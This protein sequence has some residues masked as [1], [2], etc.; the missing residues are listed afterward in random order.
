MVKPKVR[1]I[2][3]GRV[4]VES[5]NVTVVVPTWRQ[6]M[7]LA[8]QAAGMLASLERIV[9]EYDAAEVERIYRHVY[10]TTVH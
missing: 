1:I 8:F 4:E 2:A 3:P 10:G 7:S 9:A 5:F 6:A